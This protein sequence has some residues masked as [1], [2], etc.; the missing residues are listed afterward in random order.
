MDVY[1]ISNR[2]AQHFAKGM[3]EREK[4]VEIVFDNEGQPNA[5]A[6]E[7]VRFFCRPVE[8]RS[9][10]IGDSMYRG[11][12][13]IDVQVFTALGI[14]SGPGNRI[15]RSIQLIF[16]PG[17]VAGVAF[18]AVSFDRIGEVEGWLQNQVRVRFTSDEPV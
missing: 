10:A 1:A 15:A 3:Q 13:L 8:D 5:K 17:A 14:G 4:D 9:A 2:I 7:W 6:E 11:V 12:G 18:G 16:R